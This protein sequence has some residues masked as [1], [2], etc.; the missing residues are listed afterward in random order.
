MN[1]KTANL[2]CLLIGV[3]WGGGFIATDF[4]LKTFTP[5]QMLLI[6]FA[7]AALLAWIPVLVKREKVQKEAMKTGLISGCFLYIAFALQTFG[8]N[9]TEPGMN[10]FLTSVNVVLVPYLAWIVWKQKPDGLVLC[11]SLVCMAGIGFLSLSS[12]SFG[13]RWGD[14]LSLGCSVFF[15]AQIVALGRSEHLSVAVVNA[16]QLSTAAVLAIPFGLLEPWP[17]QISMETI[18]SLTYT[19]CL[20]TFLCYLMETTAQKY[21]SCAAAS[22]LM[23]TESLWA[24]IFSFLILHQVPSVMMV[25]G[26]LLIFTAILMVEGRGWIELHLL[27][28]KI[29]PPTQTSI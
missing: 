12:G 19:V 10:A 27:K 18:G 28:K 16:L 24:N 11:A 8:I 7:G 3:I 26:G 15:A 4:A 9:L 20:S 14:L 29:N 17:A 25:T 1:K 21:T 23:G 6:R 22:I 2:L 13:L 5:F